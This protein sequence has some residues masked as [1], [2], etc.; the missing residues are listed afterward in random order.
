MREAM[1]R[2]YPDTT[3]DASPAT[4]E[5]AL[6]AA[7]GLAVMRGGRL[8][9]RGLDFS[10]RPGESL[11]LQGPNGAGK[12]SLLRLVAGLLPVFAGQLTSSASRAMCDENLA[13]DTGKTLVQALDFWAGIDGTDRSRL[14][15]AMNAMALSRLA[16][17]PVRLLSTGQRK[18]AVLARVIASGADLWLLDEPGNGLDTAS[19]T[20]LGNAMAR[21]VAAG[22]AIIAASHFA[23]PFAFS[24]ALDLGAFAP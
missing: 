11:L 20:L 12:S 8:L 4:R 6:V 21:H 5:M 18:R 14:E 9:L 2:D 17:V 19:L 7:Q 1:N 16:E 23:L 3:S 13:L 10:L 22:G 24:A 15:A